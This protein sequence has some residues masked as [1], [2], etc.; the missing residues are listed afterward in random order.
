[1]R[2]LKG[3]FRFFVP[4]ERTLLFTTF[5]Q[6]QYFKM[7]SAIIAAGISHR[8]KIKGEVGN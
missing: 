8:T 4:A 6:A 1:M 5:D 2:F 7:K 3:I